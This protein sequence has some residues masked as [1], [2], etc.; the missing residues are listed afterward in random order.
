MDASAILQDYRI[1]PVVVIDDPAN[2]VPLA[3]TLLDAGIGIIEITLRT[4]SALASIRA[5][6]DALPQMRVGAGS[7]RRPL[8]LHAVIDAGASFA[9]SPGSTPALLDTAREAGFPFVPGAITPSEVL[10]LLGQGYL[11]QK[12][13]PAEAAGGIAMLK[14]MAGPIPEVCFMPTGGISESL[15][16]EYLELPNVAGVGGSW[17]APP[18]LIAAGNF[19]EIAR[20]AELASRL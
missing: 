20:R 14:S 2:A 10:C 4:E 8:H 7:I 5:V 13:F 1:T 6:A 15:A 9:I 12:F 18:E 19:G 3:Q 11:L 17:I 16:A